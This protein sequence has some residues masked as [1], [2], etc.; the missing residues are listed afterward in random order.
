[1][2]RSTRGAKYDALAEELCLFMLKKNKMMKY[3][4]LLDAIENNPTEFYRFNDAYFMMHM[5]LKGCVKE[6]I[7]QTT[8]ADSRDGS[9]CWMTYNGDEFLFLFCAEELP[10]IFSHLRSE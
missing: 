8:R 2:I 7:H 9:T 4:E 5:F 6:T 1:M 10:F 3:S